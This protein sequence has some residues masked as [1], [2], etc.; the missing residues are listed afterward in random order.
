LNFSSTPKWHVLL[1][2]AA[3][4][5]EQMDGFADMG[6]DSIE[7]NYQSR[8][9][10]RHRNSHLRDKQQAKDSQARYQNIRTLDEVKKIQS[11]VQE[12]SR[13]N[14]KRAVPL[15]VERESVRSAKRLAARA[16]NA[17]LI[18]N[19]MCAIMPT[20]GERVRQEY[21]EELEE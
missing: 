12:H 8:E 21:Q 14:L 16:G 18:E 20:P 15:R 7:Q 11:E 9:K 6:E 4:Q 13:R 5:L 3:D 19:E 2:H 1:N 17:E 10:D